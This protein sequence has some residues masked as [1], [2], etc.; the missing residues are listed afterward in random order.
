MAKFV[1]KKIYAVQLI[2]SFQSVELFI[3]TISEITGSHSGKYGD[4]HL[5]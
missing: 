3:F 4:A 2:F 1:Y 5:L